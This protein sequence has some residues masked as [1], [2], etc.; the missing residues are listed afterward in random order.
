LTGPTRKQERQVVRD[1]S[2]Q[3]ERSAHL[4]VSDLTERQTPAVAALHLAAY[5]G[6]LNVRL[7]AGYATAFLDWFRRDERAVALVALEG[8]KIAGYVVGAP[9]DLKRARNRALLPVVVREAARRPW[10]VLDARFRRAVLGRLGML[11]ARSPHEFADSYLPL[12]RLDLVS[13]AVDP[14]MQGR[15]CGQALMQEFEAV[16]RARSMRSMRLYVQPDNAAARRLYSRSGWRQL[17]AKTGR[18]GLIEYGKVL[19]E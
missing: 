4:A 14:T 13:I 15:R 7:G 8:P 11:L 5:A 1:G 12:P 6:Y 16:A 2:P 19:S 18:E 3:E 17:D 9:A 10:L